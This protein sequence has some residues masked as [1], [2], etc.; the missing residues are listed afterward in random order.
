MFE[1]QFTPEATIENF[2]STAKG[3][4]KVPLQSKWEQPFYAVLNQ[5]FIHATKNC[6]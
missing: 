2:R 4:L 3:L 1:K 5:A 6:Y